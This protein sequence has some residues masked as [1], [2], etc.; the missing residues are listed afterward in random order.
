MARHGDE[1]STRVKNL[2]EQ[3]GR[4]VVLNQVVKNRRVNQVVKNRREEPS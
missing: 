3:S 2:G 4:T 1:P